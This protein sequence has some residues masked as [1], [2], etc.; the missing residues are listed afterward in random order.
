MAG[1]VSPGIVL[2]ERDLTAQT[3]VNAQVNTAALVGSF[4]KGPIG[5]ITNIATERELVEAFGGPN[6]NNYEDWFTAATFLSY[7]GQLNVVRVED[8]TLKNAVSGAGAG[9]SDDTKLIVANATGFAASDYV[10]VDNEYFLVT[11]T[12]TGG[13]DS[14][15]VTRAQLGSTAV[16]HANGAT[17]TKWSYANSATTTVVNETIDASE[18]IISLTDATGFT[19][20]S[21][22][23]LTNSGAGSNGANEIVLITDVEGNDVVVTRAQLGTSAVAQPGAVITATLLTFAATSTTTTLA[24]TYP[25]ITSAAVTAPT[26]KSAS[27]YLANFNGYAWKFAARTAGTWANGLQVV[28]IDGGVASYDNE[29]LYGSVKWNTVAGDPGGA[30][31]LHVVVLDANNNILESFLYVSRLSTAKDEQGASKYYVDVIANKSQYIYA[32]TVTPAAGNASHILGAG[33][34][35]WTTNVSNITSAFDLFVDSEEIDIDFVLTGGSL[36]VEADQVTKAQK[37][38]A[39]ASTRKD[40][41]AFVSPH[42]GHVNLSSTSAQRDDIITFFDTVGSS[43]SYAVFDS[44][45]KY[46]YDR[47]NDTY[48]YIPCCGDVAGLCVET[49]TVL[50]DWYS[51]AGL[52]RGNLKNVVKLA[53]VPT[54]TDRDKLYQKRINPITSFAGQG[55]VLFGDKTALATPS[56]FDRINVRR[57]FLAIEKRVSTLAK[58]VLFELNDVATRSSFANAVNSYLAEV[59]AKRGVTEYLVVCD[60]TNNTA[61]VIDRN[62]FVAELYLKPA[63]SINYIT[64]TFVATRTG[65]SFDEV[66]G[67]V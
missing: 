34:D 4:A 40:C 8:A 38:I 20:G 5:T 24:D 31:D 60:E 9:T 2:R 3:I 58:G 21:Y 17:V 52:N 26:I 6:A 15:T 43:T 1:Q 64:I 25:V 10:K 39:V 29:N 54:K 62:E 14:L 53:Y 36:A 33:V 55:V 50:E 47:Y 56:A 37:A 48:R 46:I 18:N 41:I 12:T 30:N 27:D 23:R 42:K 61:D 59:Q 16:D 65:V 67:R 11:A 32:G 35:A 22:F 45:Y 63:R 13:S 49:S 57:L 7:G 28:T 66:T 44:G 19:V 51:P